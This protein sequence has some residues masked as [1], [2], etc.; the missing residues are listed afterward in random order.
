MEGKQSAELQ[1]NN[2][3]RITGG[4]VRVNLTFAWEKTQLGSKL[5]GTGTGLVVSDVITY[6]QTLHTNLSHDLQWYLSKSS[7][8]VIN[9]GISLTSM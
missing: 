1:G 6:E 4:T 2:I 5:I 3:L 7:P 8:V 9:T